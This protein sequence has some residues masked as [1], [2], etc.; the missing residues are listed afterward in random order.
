MCLEPYPIKTI[1]GEKKREKKKKK[2]GTDRD[3]HNGISDHENLYHASQI[4]QRFARCNTLFCHW[5]LWKIYRLPVRNAEIFDWRWTRIILCP[6]VARRNFANWRLNFSTSNVGG[7]TLA[8][9]T[10]SRSLDF[11]Y[12]YREKR[13][14]R[15]LSLSLSFFLLFCWAVN[16]VFCVIR[17]YWNGRRMS[18]AP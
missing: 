9:L 3:V 8:A 11:M 15:L 16:R 13:F 14:T 1:L 4:L 2:Q 7:P 17:L 10:V 5:L 6:T 12:R 18:R